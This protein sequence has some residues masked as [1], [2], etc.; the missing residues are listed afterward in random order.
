MLQA[1]L[2]LLPLAG[3]GG[4]EVCIASVFASKGD[5]WAGGVAPYLKRKVR[6]SDWGVAHRTLPL[7]SKVKVINLRTKRSTIA[8]VIDRGPYGAIY[9]GKWRVK[10]R[11]TDPGVWRGDEP[12]RRSSC[13]KSCTNR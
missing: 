8:R 2:L 3:D 4:G 1:L 11:K 13:S 7:G 5:K 9:R 6:P 10:K 12:C